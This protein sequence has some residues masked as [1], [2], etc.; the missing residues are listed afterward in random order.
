MVT[1]L[2]ERVSFSP[3][4]EQTALG[5]LEDALHMPAI[6]QQAEQL[7]P[8]VVVGLED[9]AEAAVIVLEVAVAVVAQGDIAV[10][11]ELGALVALETQLQQAA[12]A[13]VAVQQLVERSVVLAVVG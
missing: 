12:V 9:V 6:Q 13:A 3:Q 5:H 2:V 11:A 10:L 7:E 1:L 8:I 4:Q